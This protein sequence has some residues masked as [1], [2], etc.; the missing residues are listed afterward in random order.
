M[1]NIE[2]DSVCMILTHISHDKACTLHTHNKSYK[3][4][5]GIANTFILV[6]SN[7]KQQLFSEIQVKVQRAVI[8]YSHLAKTCVC[9]MIRLGTPSQENHKH[10]ERIEVVRQY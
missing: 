3:Y 9:A 6:L 2:H 4:T 1:T 10:F 7:K 8:I 5:S